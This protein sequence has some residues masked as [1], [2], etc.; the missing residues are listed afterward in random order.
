[1]LVQSFAD[2]A[3]APTAS[4]LTHTHIH[5]HTHTRTHAHAHAHA[6]THTHTQVAAAALGYTGETAVEVFV[7]LNN[8]GVSVALLNTFGD[9]VP[10]KSCHSA[11]ARARVCVCV[12]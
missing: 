4:P 1:V 9:I 10:G 2:P 11:R 3:H 5:V 12:W 7:L 6:H 8:F